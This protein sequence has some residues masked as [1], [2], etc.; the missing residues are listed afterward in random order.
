MAESVACQAGRFIFTGEFFCERAAHDSEQ[1]EIGLGWRCTGI[2]RGHLNF[3]H[4][5]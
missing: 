3:V 1:Q 2:A 5:L 4:S